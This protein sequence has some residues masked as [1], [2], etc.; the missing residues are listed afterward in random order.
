MNNTDIESIRHSLAHLLAHAVQDEYPGV[1][2]G[3]GPATEHGFYYDFDFSRAEEP[4][5][6]SSLSRLEE[7]MRELI[8]QE[9]A[10]E[11]RSVS[12]EKAKDAFSRQPYK[13]EVLSKITGEEDIRM[14]SV[15][16]FVDLCRGGHV[17]HTGEI[18]AD[19][20][21][22]TS[23]AGAYWRGDEHNPMLTRIYGAAFET[24]E[25]LEEYLQWLEEARQRD[26]RTLGK[27]LGLFTFSETV[28]KGLPLWTPKGATL[29][30]TLERFIVDEEIRRGYRHIYTPDIANIELYK[31]SGHYPYYKDAMYAPIEIDDEQFILRPMSCPHH[32]ELYQ[33]RNR[34]YRELPL[35]YAELAKLY[36]YEQS[37]ELSGLTRVR[38]F[39]LA[40]AHIIC[41]DDKQAQREITGALDLIDYVTDA[42]GLTLG[43]DYWYRLSLGNRD[44]EEKYY[45]DDDAWDTAE[46]GLRE[47]LNRRDT[48]FAE[49]PDEAAFY[50]P[51][52]DVQMRNVFGKEET[53]FTVQY[54]FVMPR[55][56]DLTYTASEGSQQRRIVVHR[57]SIGAIER[58]IAF[59]IEHYGGAFPFWLAPEQVRVLPIGEAHREYANRVAEKLTSAGL[60]ADV[61]GDDDT[62]GKRIRTGE[63]EKIPYLLIV[64]DN[65][66]TD[67]TVS[68]RER[69]TGD[70]G[71][72][73]PEEFLETVQNRTN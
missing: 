61:D 21:R 12:R 47:V 52:I 25:Q 31:K 68:V 9:L 53:A 38:A 14:Y 30:R 1:L 72:V 42:L 27:Q 35:R 8:Q 6:Q 71:A 67:G 54:D 34:S 23:V 18:P 41:T 3:I 55:R 60:R 36:R 44:D 20:F 58:I 2:F 32:F 70:T 17:E 49:A 59:L 10:F 65:E 7:R 73:K 39:C 24:R 19:A 43:T 45:K 15:G 26:H 51:K 29:R 16:D 46:A 62:I 37:G 50:G 69:G 64:G 56:F 40:D 57:S 66:V 22:L 4:F 11:G 5:S 28:G 13:L 33:S 48:D 63:T